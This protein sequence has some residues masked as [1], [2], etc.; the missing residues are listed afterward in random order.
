M[1][2]EREN[3]EG[4]REQK[5]TRST[6]GLSTAAFSIFSARTKHAVL[7]ATSCHETSSLSAV[8]TWRVFSKGGSVKFTQFPG[9]PYQLWCW[10]R[11]PSFLSTR[12]VHFAR[13]TLWISTDRF[14]CYLRLPFRFIILFW[15]ESLRMHTILPVILK[16]FCGFI[17]LLRVNSWSAGLRTI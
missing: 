13:N 4:K 9:L 8:S 16:M 6:T 10:C 11:D 14:L 12:T 2:Q 3:L 7:Q 15:G 1:E 5:D 17:Q